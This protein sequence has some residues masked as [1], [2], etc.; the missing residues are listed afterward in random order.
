MPWR[1]R[2]VE[3]EVVLERERHDRQR[4]HEEREDL[5]E[6]MDAQVERSRSSLPAPT[7][8]ATRRATW[9]PSADGRFRR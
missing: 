8:V 1:N 3:L 5:K 9:P 7:G 6:R 4:V 2:I